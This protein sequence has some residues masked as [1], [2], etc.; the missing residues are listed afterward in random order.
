M[1]SRQFSSG[2]KR[3]IWLTVIE[4]LV[5]TSILT[6]IS[7]YLRCIPDIY[8]LIQ[9]M[10][11]WFAGYQAIIFVL[12]KIRLDALKD[13][14][15]AYVNFLKYAELYLETK[16]DELELSK[17]RDVLSDNMLTDEHKKFIGFVLDKISNPSLHDKL[18]VLVKQQ[19]IHAEHS[20]STNG[21][22]WNY[23]IFVRLMK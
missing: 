5:V 1:E 7:S 22:Q 11:F 9:R 18:A 23:T 15:L 20:I 14:L 19:I 8:T 3:Q 12:V 4:I 2:V 6:W 16:S 21:L 13:S 17:F 10:V